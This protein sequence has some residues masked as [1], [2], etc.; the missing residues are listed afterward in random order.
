[1]YN[2]SN[3]CTAGATTERDSTGGQRSHRPEGAAADGEGREP[4]GDDAA[5][6]SAAGCT[7]GT[8]GGEGNHCGTSGRGTGAILHQHLPRAVSQF[9]YHSN[10]CNLNVD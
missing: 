9:Q 3:V 8:D 6:S 4:A 10:I 1:M 7:A 5:T 2:V